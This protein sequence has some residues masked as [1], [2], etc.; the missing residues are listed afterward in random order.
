MLTL[1]MSRFLACGPPSDP[2]GGAMRISHGAARFYSSGFN[3]RPVVWVVVR[4]AMRK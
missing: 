2:S 4:A 1:M 3:K